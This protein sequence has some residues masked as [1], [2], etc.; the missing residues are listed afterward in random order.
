M[1]IAS[2]TATPVRDDGALMG[3]HQ[4]S[5]QL[6]ALLVD[7]NCARRHLDDEGAAVVAKLMLAAPG[8]AVA[9]DQPGLIFEIQQGRQSFVDLQYYVS[10]TTAIPAGRATERPVFLAQKRHRTIAALAGVNV[11]S[12][13][14]DE[15]HVTLKIIAEAANSLFYLSGTAL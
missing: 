11:N 6:P 12:S 4:I 7:R 10:T 8:F 14:I 15:A 3:S 13:L 9:R 1:H 5:Q 2:T